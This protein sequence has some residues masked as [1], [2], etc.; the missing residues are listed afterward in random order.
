MKLCDE[1]NT[2]GLLNP[3][4]LDSWVKPMKERIKGMLGI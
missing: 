4:L 2:A 1:L 3:A